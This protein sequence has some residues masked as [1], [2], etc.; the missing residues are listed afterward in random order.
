MK[1][2]QVLNLHFQKYPWH[3]YKLTT[4]HSHFDKL[5]T[6]LFTIDQKVSKKY[7]MEQKS[8]CVGIEIEDHLLHSLYLNIRVL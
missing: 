4:S 3:N 6:N 1:N 2:E 7:E 8:Q 5:Y